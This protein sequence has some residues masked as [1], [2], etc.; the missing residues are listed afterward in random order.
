[1][2]L[3]YA[4]LATLLALRG[5]RLPPW[6]RQTA[7]L[8]VRSSCSAR[9]LYCSLAW[10][11]GRRVKLARVTWYPVRL[12]RHV[13]RLRV[14]ARVCIQGVCGE[15]VDEEIVGLVEW[16]RRVARYAGGVSVTHVSSESFVKRV[17]EAGADHIG[18]GLD[19]ATP[20]LAERLQKPLPWGRY[21]ELTRYAVSV[22]GE[23]RV[24]VHLIAGL[25]EKPRELADAMRLV[26]SLGARVALFP[27]TPGG[28]LG[29]RPPSL[30]YYRGA[31]L[32]RQLLDEGLDPDEYIEAGEDGWHM[33]RTPPAQLVLRA[34]LTSGCPACN[35]PYY[36]ESPRGPLYN[37]PRPPTPR[38]AEKLLGETLRCF[39]SSRARATSR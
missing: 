7:Y 12:E 15:G 2:P 25:G 6:M 3:V 21:I 27:Y 32:Y 33:R 18:I 13:E 16:L 30:C 23:G 29:G 24:Y 4:S 5:E 17:V 14:F 1:M 38:E 26:Y 9:C 34:V 31:Q 37:L 28:R 22:A 11:D 8:L 39:S 36:T 35:R 10:G 20:R 19:A